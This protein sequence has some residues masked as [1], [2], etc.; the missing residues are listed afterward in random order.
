MTIWEFEVFSW[1]VYKT[2]KGD[3]LIKLDFH[4]EE[5]FGSLVPALLSIVAQ[6]W[7]RSQALSGKSM[8]GIK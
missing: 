6:S 2:N 3:L 7:R 4:S 8:S 1:S 5:R